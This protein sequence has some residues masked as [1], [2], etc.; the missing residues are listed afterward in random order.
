MDHKVEVC[1]QNE[2][3]RRVP[4]PEVVNLTP[5]DFEMPG[6]GPISSSLAL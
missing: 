5:Q 4:A 6:V 1:G 3:C 2:G